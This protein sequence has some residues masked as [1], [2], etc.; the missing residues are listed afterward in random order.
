MTGDQSEWTAGNRSKNNRTNKR[1][2]R[3]EPGSCGHAS[4][5]D[6]TRN[7]ESRKRR[8]LPCQTRPNP[9]RDHPDN[10]VEQDN[11]KRARSFPHKT[12]TARNGKWEPR[13]KLQRTVPIM[14]KQN[15]ELKSKQASTGEKDGE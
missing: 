14:R 9:E 11:K 7:R 13:D 10:A 8:H 5:S 15:V 3:V 4:A 6:R 12:K 2:W 1:R